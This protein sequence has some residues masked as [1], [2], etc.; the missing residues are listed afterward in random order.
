MLSPGWRIAHSY[1]ERSRS[2]T[3]PLLFSAGPIGVWRSMRTSHTSTISI[4]FSWRLG[5]WSHY[6]G[7]SFPFRSE[8]EYCSFKFEI[9]FALTYIL[10]QQWPMVDLHNSQS[11]LDDQARIQL[12]IMGTTSS[13]PT[14]RNH[15]SGNVSVNYFHD[16]RHLQRAECLSQRAS[17]RC[18]TVLES[19]F[20]SYPSGFPIFHNTH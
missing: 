4:R 11:I 13:Q 5:Q 7:S 10:Y 19:T 17:N 20:P 2:S 6:S 15:A 9:T 18:R 16:C 14:L 12:R 3:L 8:I 1:R